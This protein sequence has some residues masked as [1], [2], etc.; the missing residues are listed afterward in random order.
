MGVDC[1]FVSLLYY[2]K[3]NKPL[4]ERQSLQEEEG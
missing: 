4:L 1:A 2:R 3:E